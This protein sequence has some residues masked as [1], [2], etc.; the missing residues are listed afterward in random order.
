M[1]AEVLLGVIPAGL[2]RGSI[3]PHVKQL[4][5]VVRLRAKAYR[6]EDCAGLYSFEPERLVP[7]EAVAIPYYVWGNRGE[8]E[9]RVWMN[10][11]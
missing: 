11:K 2:R 4:G 9:I 1:R 3:Q 6:A 7:C 5:G 8:N 10:V